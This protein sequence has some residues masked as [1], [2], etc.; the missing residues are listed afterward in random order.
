LRVAVASPGEVGD[1]TRLRRE[2]A[3]EQ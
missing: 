1:A 3:A 2:R